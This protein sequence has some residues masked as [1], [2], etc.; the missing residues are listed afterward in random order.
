MRSCV[1]SWCHAADRADLRIR[2]PSRYRTPYGQWGGFVNGYEGNLRE[3]LLKAQKAL[4]GGSSSKGPKPLVSAQT[5]G[6]PQTLPR[7]QQ[8]Q[9]S[10]LAPAPAP[11]PAPASAQQA[12][13]QPLHPAIRM[14]YGV[15]P[16]QAQSQAQ[17]PIAPS[18]TPMQAP[19]PA[20][21]SVP[22]KEKVKQPFHKQSTSPIPLPPYVREM[23]M[24]AKAAQQGKA[25]AQATTQ[26]PS[27]SVPASNQ[28]QIQPASA[29]ATTS[30]PQP[31]LPQSPVQTP[32]S[33][34]ASPTQ[35]K[36]QP[37]QASSSAAAATQNTPPQTHPQAYPSPPESKEPGQQG[38]RDTDVDKSRSVS[39]MELTAASGI[40]VEQKQEGQ[41]QG[42][43]L[44]QEDSQALVQKMM[45][46]LRR[47]SLSLVEEADGQVSA[48]GSGAEDAVSS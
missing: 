27:T 40:E 2:D 8:P 25:G 29:A 14:P 17:V 11:A 16:A 10:V 19:A 35:E 12:G 7:P 45:I 23:Q 22:A 13:G 30:T 43:Q 42:R 38:Q 26:Q 33:T 32:T 39:T 31:A 1:A 4:N 37:N 48:I 9:Q 36:A 21:A 44:A 18:P 3:F 47:A 5:T 34:T 20:P 41:V 6:Y 24:A 46:N 15:A 28:A